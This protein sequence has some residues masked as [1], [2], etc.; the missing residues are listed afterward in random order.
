MSET[1]TERLVYMANQIAA[2]LAAHGA[3]RAAAETAEH[4][5]RYW[6]PAMRAAIARVDQHL[7]SAIART[8]VRQLGG[9]E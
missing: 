9:A 6:D 1:G 4:M 3:D 8:A 5:A 2:N 7:L